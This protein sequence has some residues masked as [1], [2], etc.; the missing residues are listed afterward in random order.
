MSGPLGTSGGGAAGVT[1]VTAGN[2]ITV[3]GTTTPTI[4]ASLAA[5]TG[6]SIAGTT[7][8]T[9]S[10]TGV[11]S[12]SAGTGISVSGTTAL[13][14]S[15]TGV[16][17]VSAGAGISVSGSTSLTVTNTGVTALAG[18]GISVSAATGSVT[19]T[20][21]YASPTA[22]TIGGTVVTGAAASVA[23]SAH[24]HAMP[25]SAVAGAS[26]V[27][28]TAATG[29]ATTVAL[30]DH[31][32]SREAFGTPVVVNGQTTSLA[33]GSLTTLARADHVHTVSNVPVLLASTTLGSAAAS[34]TF[35]SISGSFSQLRIACIC[36]SAHTSTWYDLIFMQF[37]NDTGSNYQIDT[38]TGLTYITVGYIG[39]A[40]SRAAPYFSAPECQINGYSNSNWYTA[41]GWQHYTITSD[42]QYTSATYQTGGVWS[43]TATVTSVK[44]YLH[45]ASNFVANSTF[46]LYG[47]P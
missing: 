4:A 26:A 42:T 14:V 38:V 12:V 31:R 1:S 47:I 24:V 43:N 41:T 32:H 2:G 6:V 9:V 40:I 34:V 46:R 16:N 17:S 13:T 11:N 10:A 20:P 45:S 29:S 39:A 25:G 5:G 28:D 33:T 44:L 30:S 7:T 35:S 3:T 37:N 8:L 19:V 18:T 36:R 21:T 22:L 23:N 27:G 15:A